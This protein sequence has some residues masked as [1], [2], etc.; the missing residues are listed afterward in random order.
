MQGYFYYRPPTK[1]REG[2]IFTGMCPRGWGYG[3]EEDGLGGRVSVGGGGGLVYLFP[4]SREE[5]RLLQQVVF[6]LLKCFLVF[7]PYFDSQYFE[8]GFR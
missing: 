4:L 5:R 3:P 7:V 2:N 8:Q 6:I 1:L